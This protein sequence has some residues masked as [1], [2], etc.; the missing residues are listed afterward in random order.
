MV[1]DQDR[2][3]WLAQYPGPGRR[4]IQ[5]ADRDKRTGW[6]TGVSDGSSRAGWRSYQ[7][8]LLYRLESRSRD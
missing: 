2:Y 4:D 1:P 3:F 6:D 5:P 8:F 7:Q